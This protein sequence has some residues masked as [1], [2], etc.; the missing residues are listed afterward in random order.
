VFKRL[1]LRVRYFLFGEPS[2]VKTTSGLFKAVDQLTT[3]A[4]HHS[5]EADQKAA[6]VTT[7]NKQIG[8]HT[9]EAVSAR[10]VAANIA[11][12]LQ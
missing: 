2:V 5:T 1:F 6:Q 3:V 11:V 8:A 7:L 4:D 10:R 9:D 12:L